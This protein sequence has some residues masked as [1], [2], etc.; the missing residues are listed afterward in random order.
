MAIWEVSSIGLAQHRTEI[1]WLHQRENP[2]VHSGTQLSQ[3]TTHT[4]PEIFY[5]SHQQSFFPRAT[6]A[7]IPQG[8]AISDNCTGGQAKL[9]WVTAEV[10]AGCLLGMLQTFWDPGY[11]LWLLLSILF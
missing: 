6:E 11:I 4:L 9:S 10:K 7:E 5:F 2:V 3:K 8:M 1:L